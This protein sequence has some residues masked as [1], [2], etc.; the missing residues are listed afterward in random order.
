MI[1]CLWGKGVIAC[2]WG[3]VRVI[4]SGYISLCS[5][6]SS[7]K[8]GL[9]MEKSDPFRKYFLSS[10][11][12]QKRRTIAERAPFEQRRTHPSGRPGGSGCTHRLSRLYSD[13]NITQRT[14]NQ[15]DHQTDKYRLIGVLPFGCVSRLSRISVVPFSCV[16]RVNLCVPFLFRPLFHSGQPYLLLY[17]LLHVFMS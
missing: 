3:K 12:R 10:R 17:V 4:P 8:C 9:F 5:R 11:H 2:L 15:I 1:A 6:G 7:I 14:P 13:A 16:F